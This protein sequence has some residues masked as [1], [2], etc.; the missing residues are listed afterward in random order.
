MHD[1][2]V[3]RHMYGIKEK[4]E[5]TNA[6]Y[7]RMLNEFGKTIDKYKDDVFS[8][9]HIFVNATT[10]SRLVLLQDRLKRQRDT[11]MDYIRVSLRNFR[12]RFEEIMQ[13]LREANANFRKSFK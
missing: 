5:Q 7:D 6:E 4:L 2:R 12:K 8:L 13:Y 3:E 11:F 9:E 1:E 10:T